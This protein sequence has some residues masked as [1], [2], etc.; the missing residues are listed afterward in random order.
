MV[1][2]EGNASWVGISMGGAKVSYLDRTEGSVYGCCPW[3]PFRVGGA[4]P[5]VREG[6][7][8][9]SN[10]R[11]PLKTITSENGTERDEKRV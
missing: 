11:E 1:G 10:L 9:I 2:F 6:F 7:S 3:I 4:R 5:S 8:V